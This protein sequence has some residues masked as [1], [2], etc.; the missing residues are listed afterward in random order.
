M[1]WIGSSLVVGLTALVSMVAFA[2][3]PGSGIT[4]TDHDFTQGAY[5][6]TTPVGVCTICHT[7]HKAISTLLL[8]NHTLST[9][10]YSWDVPKTTAGT[11]FPTFSGNTY[12][13][14][15]AKCLSCHDGSVAV[16]DIAWFNDQSWPGGTGMET[17]KI[18]GSHVMT[19]STG[20]LAG[21]HPVAMPYPYQQTA[22]TYNGTTNG[23][24]LISA[25]WVA[26]PTANNIRLFVDPSGVGTGIYAGTLALKSGIE[27]SSCHEPHNSAAVKDDMFLR[28]MLTGSGQSTGYLC[29]QCHKK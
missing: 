3:S 8:W 15:T 18:T 28:G 10:T 5:Q 26:D 2:A 7:P 1:K 21:N 11:N 23:A 17:T 19:S 24:A 25:D 27:C 6:T 16:G 12:S 20:S 4:G 22:N 9:L 13:G 14:P 29:Q